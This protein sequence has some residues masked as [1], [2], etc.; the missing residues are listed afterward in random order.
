MSLDIPY[1]LVCMARDIYSVVLKARN[2]FCVHP[3]MSGSLARGSIINAAN[4]DLLGVL[5]PMLH[6]FTLHNRKDSAKDVDNSRAGHQ[7]SAVATEIGLL[8]AKVHRIRYHPIR[9]SCDSNG[10]VGGRMPASWA[11]GLFSH[12][13]RFT[14]GPSRLLNV[15]AIINK[16]L[17]YRQ[18]PLP[19]KDA[20]VA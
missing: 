12:K 16:Q 2:Q 15:T 11:V 6:C 19:Q 4:N 7:G 14:C 9:H 18:R 1:Y 13:F 3:S 5:V 10:Q 8:N 17:N 20:L